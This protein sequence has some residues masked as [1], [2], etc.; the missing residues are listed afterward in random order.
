EYSN[1]TVFVL[2]GKYQAESEVVVGPIAKTVL[3]N[4]HVE[5]LF[6]GMDDFDP[7]QGFFGRDIMRADIVE[8]MAKNAQKLIILSDSTKFSKFSLIKLANFSQTDR[9]ITDNNIPTSAR[10]VLEN[11]KIAL[12]EV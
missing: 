1:I 12:T 6:V 11:N 10:Q 7:K 9:V 4:F 8:A 3:S 2:G 5:Q